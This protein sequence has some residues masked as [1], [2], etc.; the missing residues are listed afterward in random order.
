MLNKKKEFII[1]LDESGDTNLVKIDNQ[2]PVF[3]LSAI[4]F[5]KKYF[6]DF[7]VK[8]I[9]NLKIKNGFSENIILH[10]SDIRKHRNGFESLTNSNIRKKFINDINN[11]FKNLDILI[12]SSVI[13]KYK[14]KEK[15]ET[16]GCPYDISFQ[17]ILERL[18]HFLRNSNG[19]GEIYIEQSSK[20]KESSLQK[21][22]KRL[23]ENGN[24]FVSSS[25]FSKVLIQEDLFFAKKE[26]IGTQLSDLVCYPIT[27]KVL[28]PKKENLAFDLLKSKFYG[29]NFGKIEK[30]GFKIFP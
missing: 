15:Y 19:I 13:K 21:I 18:E 22:F 12:I 24:G 7:V 29:G 8:E 9:K 4:I 10:S 26:N 17:F 25:G 11:T 20:E 23:K 14:L 1:F 3:G 28:K 5:E 30:Y 2:Y 16:P 6:Y 27:T